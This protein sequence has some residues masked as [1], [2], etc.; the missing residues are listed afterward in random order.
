[1]R[2]VTTTFVLLLG[3]SMA[4]CSKGPAPIA[5][6]KSESLLTSKPDG[7]ISV[8][9]ARKESG[10]D[11]E[12]VVVGKIGGDPKPFV[13]GIA[14][15]SIVDTSLK[16]CAPEEGCPTP[17]DYCC[18]TDKFPDAKVLVKVV[19]PSGKPIA[20]DARELLGVKEL[21]TVTV[22]G[23]VVRDESGNVT[24]VATGVYPESG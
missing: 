7:A 2:S 18:S 1:M 13:D 10:E 20:T 9:D 19:D 11:K 5:P 23:K 6:P 4:G 8:I 12:I 16:P 17:W 15:F 21:S 24:I 22:L 3:L 14:V